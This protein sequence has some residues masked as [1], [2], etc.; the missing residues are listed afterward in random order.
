MPIPIQRQAPTAGC[1]QLSV[2]RVEQFRDNRD[3]VYVSQPKTQKDQR[4]QFGELPDRQDQETQDNYL[5]SH[6]G[7]SAYRVSQGPPNNGLWNT[8]QYHYTVMLKRICR[9]IHWKV[10]MSI[11][12]PPGSKQPKMGEP[13][14][15]SGNRNHDV[16]LQWLNQFL[17]WLRSHYYCRDKADPSRLNLLGNYVEGIAADWYAADVNNPDKMTMEPTRFVDARLIEDKA[18]GEE[19][20][21]EEHPED[22]DDLQD[23]N[24]WGGSQYD[25][26]DEGDQFEEELAEDEGHEEEE[27]IRQDK[28]YAMWRIREEGEI[29]DLAIF[30]RIAEPPIPDIEDV[31]H[32]VEG[33]DID[34]GSST[35]NNTAPDP[36]SEIEMEEPSIDGSLNANNSIHSI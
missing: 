8:E 21:Q 35:T 20:V 29:E 18:E 28:M 36:T 33:S 25:P 9:L 15:Y 32:H 34:A 3:D 7:I 6:N 27:D 4:V 24:S 23:V 12:T 22:Q 26:E 13:H 16:F 1:S 31:I 17:N 19:E 2:P 14:K 11:T 10:G 5:D 30:S